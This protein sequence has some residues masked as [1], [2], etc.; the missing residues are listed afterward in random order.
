MFKDIFE[1][2]P[3]LIFNSQNGCVTLLEEENDMVMKL[4]PKSTPKGTAEKVLGTLAKAHY[5][6]EPYGV[7]ENFIETDN[8]VCCL[9]FVVTSLLFIVYLH[10]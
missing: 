5:I 3:R 7:E 2:K 8:E 6:K 9:L 1:C 10:G 4:I